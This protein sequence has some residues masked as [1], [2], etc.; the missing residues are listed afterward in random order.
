MKRRTLLRNVASGAITLPFLST[1][2]F[3]KSLPKETLKEWNGT[4]TLDKVTDEHFW[5]EVRKTHY[6]ITDEWINL[7]NGYFGVQPKMVTD[8]YIEFIRKVNRENSGY[9]RNAFYQ[10]AY[11]EIMDTLAAFTGA[12]RDE[13]LITR[14]ATEAL[15]I[16]IQGLPLDAG[17]EVILH[18]QDYPSMIE[19]FEMLEKNRGISIR[20][21]DMPFVPKDDAEV[22]R[23]YEE[24][25][26]PKTKCIL[27]THM[28]HLTGQIMPA[29]L[30]ADMARPK[31]I[32][33]IV[34]GAHSFAHLDYKIPDLGC[35]FV[36]VNLHKW[37][38]TPIGMGMMYI[39]K[40]RIK[41]VSPLFGEVDQKPDNIH[42]LGHFGTLAF[43][44]LL[45]VPKAAEFN[46]LVT[47]PVKEARLRYLQNYWTKEIAGIENAEM[48]TPLD[49]GRSCAIAT[50]KMQN[51]K[52]DEVIKRLFEDFGVFTVKRDLPGNEEGIRVTPN[53][54]IGTADVDRILE[55][56][57]EL[58][59]A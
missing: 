28:I 37:F 36:G 17:D 48:L 6:D 59:Q 27:V 13:L 50:F 10:Q 33:V 20:K 43:P 26:T 34:D 24:A 58:S 22:V 53:L 9:A 55:G 49:K 19:A 54:Y 29:K 1:R 42:K 44:T 39:K 18:D 5:K 2:S 57:K 14:N 15:N 12:D 47:A 35:D 16:L 8:A 38:S 52:A 41:D 46:N 32:D 25:I 51:M 56:I 40:S 21:I 11:G 7:E 31:G 3:A 4:F 45:T 23:L 30:I